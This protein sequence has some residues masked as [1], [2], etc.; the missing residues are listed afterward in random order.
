MNIYATNDLLVK[1][2]AAEILS[3]LGESFWNSKYIVKHKLMK[4][5]FK[6]AFVLFFFKNLY[7]I[8]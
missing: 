7:F 2:N 3:H 4:T 8:F 1:L 5:I 6:E